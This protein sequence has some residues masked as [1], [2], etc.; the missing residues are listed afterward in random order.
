MTTARPFKMLVRNARIVARR[1]RRRCW[2]IEEEDVAAD[3]FAAQLSAL[4]RAQP[5]RPL[6]RY[7]WQVAVNA[8]SAS[9]KRASAPVSSAANPDHLVGLYRAPLDQGAGSE[10]HMTPRELVS[11]STPFDVVAEKRRVERIRE[12]VRV[13]LGE[14]GLSFAI[15]MLTGEFRPAD[16]SGEHGIPVA[17]VYRVVR[18]I[19]D[20]L[21]SDRELYELWR[22]PE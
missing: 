18:R 9:V 7:T 4:P 2:W 13:L 10:G 22:Q 14:D 16:V 21:S 12:R 15:D 3:A 19:R 8:A 17:S 1:Y 5:D 6:I 11:Y 20:T